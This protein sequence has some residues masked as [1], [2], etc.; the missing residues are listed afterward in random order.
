MSE[1]SNQVM[2][3]SGRFDR[4]H[5]GH[6]ATIAKLGERYKKVIVVI[7][8]YKEQR[9][10]AEYRY[11]IMYELL[12]RTEGEYELVVDDKHFAEISKGDIGKFEFDV[13]GSGNHKCLNHIKNLGYKVEFVPRSFDYEAS[14]EAGPL[15]S[16][17]FKGASSIIAKGVAEDTIGR[18]AQR[19]LN[20]K[21]FSEK[22]KY[23]PEN[24]DA[25]CTIE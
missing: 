4:P 2:L 8:D 19:V 15:V 16:S 13:Y 25:F 18:V 3:F 12:N 5:V 6:I 21:S 22:Y 10:I 17:D 23:T 7:L 9:Y 14:V 20:D 24:S 11:H 1:T